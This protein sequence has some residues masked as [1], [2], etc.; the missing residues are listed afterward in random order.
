MGLIMRFLILTLLMMSG[1]PGLS[2]AQTPS[3]ESAAITAMMQYCI[4]PVT[5]GNNVEGV[6]EVAGLVAMPADQA[7][8]YNKRGGRA[9]GVP[10]AGDNVILLTYGALPGCSMM[11]RRID[12]DAFWSAADEVF[13]PGTGFEPV[14]EEKSEGMLTQHYT[15]ALG[16][17]SNLVIAARTQPTEAGVQLIMTFVKTAPQQ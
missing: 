15:T 10:G 7:A 1:L 17:Q 3:P 2:Y 5:A 4:Q 9:Y 6:A 13:R 16:G 8:I 11:V 12:N 14:Q